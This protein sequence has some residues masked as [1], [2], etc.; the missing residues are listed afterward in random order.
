M[1]T[2][3]TVQRLNRH[4]EDLQSSTGHMATKPR[5]KR[6][7]VPP[8]KHANHHSSDV[9]LF[10]F[11]LLMGLLVLVLRIMAAAFLNKSLTICE[12]SPPLLRELAVPV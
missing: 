8:T 11:G 6:I 9:E 10:S 2:R 3:T 1:R 7:A 5:T 4:P 12:V